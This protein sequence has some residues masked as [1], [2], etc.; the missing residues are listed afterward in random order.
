MSISRRDDHDVISV[1]NLQSQ[2]LQTGSQIELRDRV[3]EDDFK[4]RYHGLDVEARLVEPAS[5]E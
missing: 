1:F 4:L 2:T 3:A 5:V